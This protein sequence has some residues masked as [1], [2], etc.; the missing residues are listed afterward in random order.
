LS[1]YFQAAAF[2]PS[3]AEAISRSAAVSAN[4]SSGNIGMDARNDI[5]W[6][7][8]WIARLTETE[9]YFDNLLKTASS[10]LYTLCYTS[11]LTQSN[12][13]YT[14]ETIDISF[15]TVLRYSGQRINALNRALQA[16]ASVQTGLDATGRKKEWGLD[17]WSRQT[18]TN[19]RPYDN[20]WKNF[21]VAVEL[22]NSK[23]QIIGKQTFQASGTGNVVFG[24]SPEIRISA[25]NIRTITFANVKAN[26]I[27]DSL[28][29]RIASVN[30]LDA[31]TAAQNGV[32]QIRLLTEA[33]WNF[34][35]DF[36]FKNGQITAYKGKGGTI[37]IDTVWGEPVTSI[38]GDSICKQSTYQRNHWYKC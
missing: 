31:K 19:L 22:V 10:S 13:N 24:T 18:V 33:E 21:T 3:M 9:Q 20:L 23:N 29:I 15:L 14:N 36:E 30:G 8:D 2:D 38:G 27:T 1:Y 35:N 6:R 12:I 7:K 32:L 26:D 16:V 4:I 5:Q 17:G 28:T 25:G 37:V 11:D 34:S